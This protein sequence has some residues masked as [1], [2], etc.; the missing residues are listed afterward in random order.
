MK[1]PFYF[2]KEVVGEAFTDRTFEVRGLLSDIEQGLN[3]IIYSPRRYGKTS[4]IK[5]VLGIARERGIIVLYLDL[6]PITNFRDFVE[7]YARALS[8][9]EP[10][11]KLKGFINILG[12]LIPKLM[13][14]VTLGPK[15]GAEI[16]FDLGKIFKEKEAVL[17]DLL[18]AVHKL[19]TR[20]RKPAVVV[21]DEF[22]EIAKLDEAEKLERQI[23]THIQKQQNVAYI[24]LGSKRHL[25]QDMF[26]NKNRPLYNCGRHFPLEKI[27]SD[28]FCVFINQR[29]AKTG[30]NINP[31]DIR[32]ILKITECHPYYTQLFCH[33]LWDNCREQKKIFPNHITAVLSQLLRE[34]E[35]S[36]SIIW[37]DLSAVQ[38]T[39]VKALAADETLPLFSHAFLIKYGL[40]S[41]SAVQKARRTLEKK[42]IIERGNGH[43][44]ISDLFL[45]K[46]I[47]RL[48]HPKTDALE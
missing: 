13:P 42:E 14:K 37:D 22:Q 8:S 23:R 6:Y 31:N 15:G 45:K 41:A 19:A 21:F 36:Y 2:G 26:K 39:L 27:S 18:E 17:D 25:M 12:K 16:T 10:P 43:Y 11:S 32:M 9:S 28:D 20:K 5:K 33:L 7:I 40:N 1:N 38:R 48:A 46:W 24:F 44:T 30:I 4:L 3:I 34:E 35:H 29:F 47:A